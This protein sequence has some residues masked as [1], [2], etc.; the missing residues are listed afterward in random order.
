M[1]LLAELLKGGEFGE[2]FEEG[3]AGFDDGLVAFV[4][5]ELEDSVQR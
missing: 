1:R 4:R 5:G 2:H 3:E